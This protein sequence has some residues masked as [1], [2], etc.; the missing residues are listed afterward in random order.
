MRQF[1]T[2]AE[3]GSVEAQYKIGQ[4]YMGDFDKFGAGGPAGSVS[5]KEVSLLVHAENVVRRQH[6]V[7]IM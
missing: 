5:A 2:A 7:H 4:L 1:N 6:L 3:L